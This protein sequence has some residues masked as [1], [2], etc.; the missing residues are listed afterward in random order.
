MRNQLHR[1]GCLGSL[2][3]AFTRG[4]DRKPLFRDDRDRHTFLLI[5]EQV[6]G[7]TSTRCF[8]FALMENHF[9]LQLR[10]VA[11]PLSAVMHRIKLRYAR[12][13]N[14]RYGGTGHVFEGRFKSVLIESEEHLLTVLAYI[15]LNPVRAGLVTDEAALADYPWTGHAGLLGRRPQAFLSVAEVLANLAPDVA[16]A[17]ARLRGFVRGALSARPEASASVLEY[18]GHHADA[19]DLSTRA[20]DDLQA[21]NVVGVL[22]T[23]DRIDAELRRRDVELWARRRLA[24]AGWDEA[25]VLTAVCEVAGVSPAAV[26]RGSRR[27]DHARA[28]ALFLHLVTR[29]LGTPRRTAARLVG[30]TGGNAASACARGA[31]LAREPGGVPVDLLVAAELIATA[32][33]DLEL[34]LEVAN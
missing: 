12:Y 18:G 27:A 21:R 15:N 34:R 23:S 2:V 29:L 11:T 26:R 32:H 1:L 31:L 33:G 9:H 28:R 3:H 20:A 25:R 16:T 22:G 17:R 8:T 5:L 30:V 19:L 14:R 10:T 7:D 4:L 13:H 24:A 6:L